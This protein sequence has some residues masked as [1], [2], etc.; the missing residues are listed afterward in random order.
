MQ[1]STQLGG[2][3]GHRGDAHSDPP[4]GRETTGVVGYLDLKL[5]AS[6]QFDCAVALAPWRYAL[7]SASQ[8]IRKAATST[9]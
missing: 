8:T 9:A 4:L 7:L 1:D 6:G 2:A 3:L 5:S